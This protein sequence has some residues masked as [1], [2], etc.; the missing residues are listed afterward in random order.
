MSIAEENNQSILHITSDGIPTGDY[1]LVIESYDSK[2][3]AQPTLKTDI[4]LIS[5]KQPPSSLPLALP[6]RVISAIEPSSWVLDLQLEEGSQITVEVPLNLAHLV[7]FNALTMTIL[8]SGGDR[9]SYFS[10]KSY[11]VKIK[12]AEANGD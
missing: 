10:G 12:V 6:A 9:S 3:S 8:F 11:S 1:E 2:S 7:T 5:V 4:I